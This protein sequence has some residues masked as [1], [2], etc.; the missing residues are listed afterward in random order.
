MKKK[1][2]IASAL[3]VLLAAGG[4]GGQTNEEPAPTART[5]EELAQ[6]VRA[7]EL[8]FAQSMADRNLEAFARH[9]AAET[10]F[11]SRQGVLRGTEAVVEAWKPFFA[12]EEAPF[13]WE[14]AQV[15]VLDSGSLALSSGPVRDPEGKQVGTFTS[16]WRLE[17][18]GVWRIIFD[19]GCPPCDCGG[20]KP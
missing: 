5:N 11:F 19:K 15:E 13:S 16:I 6:Q 17:A 10:V 2:L 3:G 20:Q 1:F 18:D 4:S 8:A 9:L 14:P 12:E 7:V